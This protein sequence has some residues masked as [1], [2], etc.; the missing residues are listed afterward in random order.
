ME[1]HSFQNV[2]EHYVQ[3]INGRDLDMTSATN[4]SPGGQPENLL[5]NLHM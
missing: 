4:L 3:N 5:T 2:D 1:T